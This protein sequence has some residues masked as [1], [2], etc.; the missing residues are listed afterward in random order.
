[1]IVLSLVGTVLCVLEQKVN[2]NGKAVWVQGHY[3][4]RNV[5]P[6]PELFLEKK[7]KKRDLSAVVNDEEQDDGK[8]IKKSTIL[9]KHFSLP[10]GAMLP[11]SFSGVANEKGT[12]K[13]QVPRVS[14]AKQLSNDPADHYE[15]IDLKEVKSNVPE[16]L[17]HST[18]MRSKK[19]HDENGYERSLGGRHSENT[20]SY[21]ITDED[22]D[23][24]MGRG[25]SGNR[26]RER[27]EILYPTNLPEEVEDL[28]EK[29]RTFT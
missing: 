2:A 13:S 28:V 17:L 29:Q 19:P 18:T 22:I 23:G 15:L 16:A 7:H 20:G 25:L 24:L 14:F 21:K 27:N 1:M 10:I 6:R 4:N 3:R 5:V 8:S 11:I 12:K 26:G 9:R